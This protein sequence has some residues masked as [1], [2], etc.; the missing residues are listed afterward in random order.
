MF[1]D[2]FNTYRGYALLS[3]A[4]VVLISPFI[5]GV[6]YAISWDTVGYY[7]Y[8]P[9]YFIYGSKMLSLDTIELL[10][11]KYDFCTS[12]YHF[13][14]E[15]NGVFVNKYTIG[16]ALFQL[17]F[18][19]VAHLIALLLGLSADGFSNVYTTAQV[20]G[21][22]LYFLSAL[23]ILSKILINYVSDKALAISLLILFFGTNVLYNYTH[24][25]WYCSTHNYL[26][27]G[28]VYLLGLLHSYSFR[29]KNKTL[30][31]IGLLMSVI[32]LTRPA[33]ASI[34]LLLVFPILKT[35][36]IKLTKYFIII[37]AGMML[38]FVLQ[39]LYWKFNTGE[40]I[41]FGY[42]NP[43]EGFG[44]PAQYLIK[45]LFYYRKGWLV[46][47][48]VMIFAL[49]G[50]VILFKQKR[51]LFWSIAPF[52]VVN[53]TIICSWSVWWWAESYGHR[54]MIESY[55]LL[56]FPLA[57]LTESILKSKFSGLYI[58]ITVLLCVLNIFKL[59]QYSVGII[60]PSRMTKEY[61]WTNFLATKQNPHTN[62]LLLIDRNKIKDERP[63]TISLYNETRLLFRDSV[64]LEGKTEYPF[65]WK[66][67]YADLTKGDHIFYRARFKIVK[68]DTLLKSQFVFYTEHNKKG[69]KYVGHY[70]NENQSN[71]LNEYFYLS[72]EV[73]DNK[74]SI[75]FYFYNQG[76]GKA[77]LK[78]FEL[79]LLIP[80]Q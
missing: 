49:L 27:A 36:T 26:F 6:E 41:Y 72:P 67:A 69:Y 47:T 5:S 29:L 11:Q 45:N 76:K 58:V 13:N 25:T 54:A 17:P 12:I 62:S 37:A 35:Q 71:N 78:N 30:F 77:V 79:F 51:V 44:Y 14:L 42:K 4:F 65:G 21:S 10:R 18:F 61:Y 9:Q 7:W 16:Q 19:I 53:F 38:P 22:V 24:Q 52:F 20:T 56:V 73:R 40:W 70:L 68:H 1:K 8:L 64:V 15:A 66:M 33:S 2:L 75:G 23:Y 39:L 31:L 46:Y 48:P 55:A 60:N 3:I 32:I 28:I 50:F 59:W 63:D 80:K 43:A 74:D 57:C 34:V